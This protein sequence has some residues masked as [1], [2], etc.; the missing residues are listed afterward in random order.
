MTL[1]PES[2]YRHRAQTAR[3]GWILGSL[4]FLAGMLVLA[5]APVPICECAKAL[6]RRR[7]TPEQEDEP[8]FVTARP[9]QRAGRK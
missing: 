5:A 8:A 9:R 6:S 4:G 2:G 1:I 7:S 3:I